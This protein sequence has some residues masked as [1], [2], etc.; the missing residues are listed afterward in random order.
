MDQV[1]PLTGYVGQHRLLEVIGLFLKLGVIT[2]GGPAATWAAR[3]CSSGH[4]CGRSSLS[5]CCKK[6]L[7]RS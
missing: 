1:S 3:R 6:L 2:F 7:N 5:C 4:C